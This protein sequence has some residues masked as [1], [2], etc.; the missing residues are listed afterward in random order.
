MSR[1]SSFWHTMVIVVATAFVLYMAAWGF[2][3][4]AGVAW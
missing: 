4:L 3:I 1:K 2:S